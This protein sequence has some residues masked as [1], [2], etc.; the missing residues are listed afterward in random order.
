[1]IVI[2]VITALSILLYLLYPVW[3]GL[4]SKERQND[5]DGSETGKESETGRT[6]GV[7]LILLSYNGKI[8]LSEKIAFLLKELSCFSQHELIIV[9]DNSDDNSLELL[10][11]MNYS[12]IRIIRKKLHRGIPDSMNI[13]VSEAKYEHIIFCD[14]RQKLSDNILR[15]IVGPLKYKHVGAVSGYIS[16]FNMHN[17]RSMIRWYENFLKSKESNAGS[18]MGVYGPLY[19]IKK[20]CYT[21]IPNDIILDDLY[22]SLRILKLKQIKISKD[23]Q[24]IDEDF[25]MLYNYKRTVRYL[26]GLMQILT[27]K[28]LIS[29]LNYK[30]RLMLFMH[31]YLR[32]II[33]VFLFMS[34]IS[35]A[36][37]M[38]HG[39][40][41]ILLFSLLTLIGFL[42]VLPEFFKVRVTLINAVRIN[43]LYFIALLNI[44]FIDI[45]YKRVMLINRKIQMFLY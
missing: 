32:L 15:R 36:F 13:G 4:I 3:L 42:A 31:K 12:D 10:E 43:I 33:P 11:K 16:H 26:T 17:E 20:E 30:Q 41:Y 37:M 22:L 34:Y 18:L 21:M 24:I 39:T 23:C 2:F 40:A 45:C 7:S 8:Y 35:T 29:D 27:A 28:N 25:S 14:Q 9:D 5:G 6:S 44:L 19:A 38:V 1:M